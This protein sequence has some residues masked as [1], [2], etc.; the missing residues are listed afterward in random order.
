[1]DLRQ[2]EYFVAVVEEGG[3]RKASP[4]IFVA[5][6]AISRAL[7]QLERDLG[8]ELFKREFNGVELTDAGRA[9]L[10]HAP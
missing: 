8:A 1:M 4:R 3:Y 5:Q 6:S 10:R 2:L 7:Q 9:L